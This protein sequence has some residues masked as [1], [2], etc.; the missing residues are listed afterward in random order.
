MTAG[1]WHAFPEE[2]N[3]NFLPETLCGFDSGTMCAT[4]CGSHQALGSQYAVPRFFFSGGSRRA[5][6][7]HHTT[8]AQEKN[9]GW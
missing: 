1:F 5:T 2:N 6:M 3:R 8:G 7:A 9:Q 4:I